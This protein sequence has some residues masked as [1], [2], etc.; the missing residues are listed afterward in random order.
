RAAGMGDCRLCSRAARRYPQ[1]FAAQSGSGNPWRP[2]PR[3]RRFRSFE[4]G[5]G[6]TQ[7]LGVHADHSASTDSKWYRLA[8]QS[9]GSILGGH[10]MKEHVSRRNVI[11]GAL[12][13]PAAALGQ[14]SKSAKPW[15]QEYW[16]QKGPV[17]L[18][19]FRKRATPPKAGEK[20][21]PVLL[22]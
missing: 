10:L 8:G 5:R 21:L 6:S 3:S 22:P 12:L 2:H 17:K 16:A 19:M 14:S 13:A 11:A 1:R 15:A 4:R 9:A 20:P 18:Y 7:P